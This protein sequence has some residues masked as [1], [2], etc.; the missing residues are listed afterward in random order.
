[1]IFWSRIIHMIPCI[2]V[3]ENM[4]AFLSC[5]KWSNLFSP[6]SKDGA[7]PFVLDCEKAQKWRSNTYHRINGSRKQVF[8]KMIITRLIMYL[9]KIWHMQ[10][11]EQVM[12]DLSVILPAPGTPYLIFK[13]TIYWRN[14]DIPMIRLGFAGHVFLCKIVITRRTWHQ[15]SW[16]FVCGGYSTCQTRFWWSRGRKF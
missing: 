8:S 12:P 14:Y 15:M 2:Y 3:D 4:L 9:F 16:T 13:D 7:W 5:E 6:M 11:K 10:K 1:M